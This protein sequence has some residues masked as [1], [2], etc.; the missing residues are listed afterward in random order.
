MTKQEKAE[1]IQDLTEKFRQ[2]PGF[3][4]VNM[5]GMTVAESN[6]FRAKLHEAKLKVHM[7]KNTLLE[8]A[9]EQIGTSELTSMKPVLKQ[10]SSVIYVT[11]NQSVPAKILMEF[12]KG[13]AG[14]PELKGAFVES[15]VFIG[16]AALQQLASLKSKNELLGEIVGMLQS[17]MQNLISALQSNAGEKVAGLVQAVSEKKS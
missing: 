8:K 7:V 3:Y 17:P 9:F 10:S 15:S 12:R 11:E 16:D 1:I 2:N 14:K 4:I 6:K 5:S 13:A